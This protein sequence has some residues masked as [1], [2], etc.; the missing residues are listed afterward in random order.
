M[1]AAGAEA[2]LSRPHVNISSQHF[3][4]FKLVAHEELECAPYWH[5]VNYIVVATRQVNIAF[6]KELEIQVRLS[7]RQRC[8][9][10]FSFS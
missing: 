2:F 7:L 6:L 1:L 4:R 5:C 10:G 8:S 3:E 9:V